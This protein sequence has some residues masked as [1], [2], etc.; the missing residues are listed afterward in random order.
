MALALA[1]ALEEAS[2]CISVVTNADAPKML[3]EGVACER[4][5]LCLL[6]KLAP[7]WPSCV[8]GC[9]GGCVRGCA[10][11][12]VGEE[13][14]TGGGMLPRL[15]CLPPPPNSPSSSLTH[16]NAQPGG[17]GLTRWMHS[18]GSLTLCTRERRTKVS[19]GG[20]LDV[21]WVSRDGCQG[22]NLPRLSRQLSP[23]A[24]SGSPG[25]L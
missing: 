25:L 18:S 10:K 23:P 5:G 11:A 8:S 16:P 3:L 19:G 13:V 15:S 9:G 17:K 24:T 7:A 2:Q 20:W 12:G 22:Q 14:G 4:T 21:V 1:F 6:Y